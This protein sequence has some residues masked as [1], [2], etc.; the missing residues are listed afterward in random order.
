MVIVFLIYSNQNQILIGNVPL[1]NS[2]TNN[3][4]SIFFNL[5]LSFEG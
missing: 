5:R 1:R 2:N 4:H 3:S